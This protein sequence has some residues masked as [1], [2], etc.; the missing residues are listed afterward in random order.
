MKIL[1]IENEYSSM[2][3]QWKMRIL[4]LKNDDFI[5]KRAD[6]G[7]A[8]A[9]RGRRPVLYIHEDSSIENEAILPLKVKILPLKTDH[10]GATRR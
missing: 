10:F 5:D 8:W 2:N 4:Q 9:C 1:M 6:D 7:R 3:L